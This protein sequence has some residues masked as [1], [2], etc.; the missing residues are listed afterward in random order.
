MKQIQ[1]NQ[2]WQNYLSCMYDY[3]T[4]HFIP[5]L[6]R[7]G[8]RGPRSSHVADDQSR[9][10]GGGGGVTHRPTGPAGKLQI[11]WALAEQQINYITSMIQ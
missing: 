7:F 4:N 10:S 1:T 6:P 8:A 11:S 3:I 2:I 9:G 5:A